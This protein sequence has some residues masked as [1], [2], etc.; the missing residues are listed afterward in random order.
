MAAIKLEWW[1][2]SDWNKWPPSSESAIWGMMSVDVIGDVRRAY[3]D[4][5]LPIKEIVRTLS[6][7]RAT[8]RKIIRSHKTEFKYQPGVQAVPR[9]GAWVDIRKRRGADA[10]DLI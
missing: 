7:S 1:P 9:L 8:V 6:V 2:G 4:Q 5:H 3:F 10:A